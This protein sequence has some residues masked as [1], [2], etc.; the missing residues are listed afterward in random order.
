MKASPDPDALVPQTKTYRSLKPSSLSN[1]FTN[2]NLLNAA[3]FADIVRVREVPKEMKRLA[4]FLALTPMLLFSGCRRARTGKPLDVLR[5]IT[6]ERR[7]KLMLGS[8]M[9]QGDSAVGVE[10]LAHSNPAHLAGQRQ[11][12]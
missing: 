9:P 11:C 6:V 1:Q 8:K 5:E 4:C 12:L 10:Q 3:V 2:N 7:T